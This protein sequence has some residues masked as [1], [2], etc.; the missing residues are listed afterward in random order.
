MEIVFQWSTYPSSTSPLPWVL[1]GWN[2]L[3]IVSVGSLTLFLPTG[4]S[5]QEA[6]ARETDRK[7][8]RPRYFFPE[9]FPAGSLEFGYVLQLG[10]QLLSV[11]SCKHREGFRRTL[12]DS[13]TVIW[14]EEAKL[15]LNAAM[16]WS[17]RKLGVLTRRHPCMCV[18]KEVMHSWCTGEERSVRVASRGVGKPRE[19][20]LIKCINSRHLWRLHRIRKGEFVGAP[21]FMCITEKP[22]S[23]H[24]KG[25]QLEIYKI[26]VCR[27]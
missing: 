11:S 22:V 4:F 26:G 1:G 13:G 27:M 19:G 12:P 21:S 20:W 16:G 9:S 2:F 7:K 24:R 3:W 8:V 17:D 14:E 25:N 6:P 18:R 10:A 23:R 15:L 5:Q